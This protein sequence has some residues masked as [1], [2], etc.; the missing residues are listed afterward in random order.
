MLAVSDWFLSWEWCQLKTLTRCAT[1]TF[2]FLSLWWPRI[3]IFKLN[4]APCNQILMVHSPHM[5]Q[6]EIYWWRGVNKGTQHLMTMMGMHKNWCTQS[7]TCVTFLQIYGF[8]VHEAMAYCIWSLHSNSLQ[9]KSVTAKTYGIWQN[10]GF[11]GYVAH[12]VDC[13]PCCRK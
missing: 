11:D 12:R 2:S 13:M 5:W 7:V 4:V 8:S 3:W 10:M 6:E 9:T 1:I